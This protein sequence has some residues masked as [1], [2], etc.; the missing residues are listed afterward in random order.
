[1]PKAG[2]GVPGES[3]LLGEY[4]FFASLDS[5]HGGSFMFAGNVDLEN[6]SAVQIVIFPLEG[7]RLKGQWDEDTDQ[8]LLCLFNTG[9]FCTFGKDEHYQRF[10]DKLQIG[11]EDATR[12]AAWLA[13]H[14]DKW[15]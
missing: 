5:N 6:G 2:S 9:S 15:V 4:N 14:E 1:V 3:K 7:T 13:K 10:K 11:Q 8:Y 12:L